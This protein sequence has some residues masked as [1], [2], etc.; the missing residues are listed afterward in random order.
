MGQ[1]ISFQPCIWRNEYPVGTAIVVLDYTSSSSLAGRFLVELPEA[2]RLRAERSGG[3]DMGEDDPIC[4]IYRGLQEILGQ[5][6]HPD[7]LT[8]LT[9]IEQVTTRG[10]QGASSDRAR[11]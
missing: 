11:L 1:R 2:T 10:T 6:S 4:G 9:R 3:G 7:Y 5:V 8:G